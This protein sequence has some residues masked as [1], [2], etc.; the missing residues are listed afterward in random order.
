MVHGGPAE[1]STV[2]SQLRNLKKSETA[3]ATPDERAWY[4]REH[5]RRERHRQRILDRLIKLE[6]SKW[7]ARHGKPSTEN[8]KELY[9]DWCPNYPKASLLLYELM[10]ATDWA[11]LPNSG[12]WLDQDEA[13][14]EDITL[15]ARKAMFVRAHVEVN[16]SER[17]EQG[18]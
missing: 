12:G 5:A 18:R 11:H 14:M 6:T 15:L 7:R 8:D 1:E 10:D 2:R 17:G 16:E 3:D 13:L 4:E 9:E